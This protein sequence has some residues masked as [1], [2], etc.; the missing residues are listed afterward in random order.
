MAFQQQAYIS[1]PGAGCDPVTQLWLMRHKWK[2]RVMYL[3]SILKR[4]GADLPLP[5]PS[6]VFLNQDVM[7]GAAA[8]PL[9][10]SMGTTVKGLGCGAVSGEAWF[11]E[12]FV[13]PSHS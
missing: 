1:E 6:P 8:A 4:E 10:T 2:C 11:L 12:L 5:F 7:A 9:T 13:P 3:E